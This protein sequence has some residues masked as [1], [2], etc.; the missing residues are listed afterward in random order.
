MDPGP[1][2]FLIAREWS[3]IQLGISKRK[4][5]ACQSFTLRTQLHAF[6]HKRMLSH[7]LNNMASSLCYT[8]GFMPWNSH[9]TGIV[10]LHFPVSLSSSVVIW[11]TL[12]IFLSY[13]S[14]IHSK[15]NALWTHAS[16]LI[17]W[18]AG[19]E[20]WRMCCIYW[21][22]DTVWASGH[23]C[24]EFFKSDF[25]YTQFLGLTLE[26]NLQIRWCSN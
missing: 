18:V 3:H 6:G 20:T 14:T 13:C 7:L 22:R 23:T 15:Q 5:S 8:R 17:R 19:K 16:C 1:K 4:H 21:Q 9:E 25:D 26:H 10:D 2:V 24:K 12:S 11:K